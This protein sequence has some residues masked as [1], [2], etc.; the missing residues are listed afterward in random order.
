MTKSAFDELIFGRNVELFKATKDDPIEA[1]PVKA[2]EELK[3]TFALNETEGDNVLQELIMGGEMNRFG[4]IN[5]VTAMAQK[6]DS[7][8]RSTEL[9]EMGAKLMALPAAQWNPIANAA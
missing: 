8:D 5:A 6:V 1:R 7:Y 2:V 9:E 4:L 3:N